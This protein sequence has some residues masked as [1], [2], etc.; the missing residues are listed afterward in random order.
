MHLWPCQ[1]LTCV[2]TGPAKRRE[3]LH[4]SESHPR[5]GLV[6]TD[7]RAGAPLNAGANIRAG[8]GYAHLHGVGVGAAAAL[9]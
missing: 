3:A 2:K 5:G 8:A 4:G 9:V 1:I 6:S 7:M